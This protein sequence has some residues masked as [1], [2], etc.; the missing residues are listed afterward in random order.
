MHRIVVALGSCLLLGLTGCSGARGT[1]AKG[2]S[3]GDPPRKV[4]VQK[5]KRDEI[6]RAVEIVGTLA[7]WDE[8]TVS[9]EAEGKVG[10]ILADLG[11]R[12]S[13]GQ[14]LVELDR[15]KLQYGLDQQKAALNRALARY[16]VNEAGQAL[17]PIES[18]PEVKK[19]EAE[20]AQAE[21]SWK[22]ADELYRR[23]LLPKQQLDD[24]EAKYRTAKAGYDSAIQNGKNLRADIDAS[25][26]S[27]HL[28]ERQLRDASI[29]AP[30]DGYVQKRLVSMGQFVRVQT[31]IMSVVKVNPLKV[32]AEVPERMAPWIK[33]GQKVELQVDAYPDRAIRGTIIRISP[34]VNQQTRAFPLEA[35]VPNGEGLLKPGTFARV[36]IT[37]DKVDTILT[38]PAVALQYR[39]G[40]N[41]VFL[42][43]GDRLVS[44]E[45]KLGDRL[46]D[47][48]EI[49]AG[50][51]AGD[52]V[53]VS[54]VEKLADGLRVAPQRAE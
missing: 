13:G 40:V 30:F 22:R 33:V 27:V 3:E 48:V 41:R 29:R 53:A 54:D 39:Y 42:V 21:Q 16:G 14:V 19:A 45:V 2:R 15:E 47:R 37:S 26:A 31:S 43:K 50:V 10:R 32:T 17:P 52:P 35:E 18:T 34:A 6:H 12:V 1:E 49:V 4:K 5:V 51:D 24:A 8:V 25:E 44:R 20:L 38:V 46:G 11:D 23:S 28:A 7:A 36:H 9:S